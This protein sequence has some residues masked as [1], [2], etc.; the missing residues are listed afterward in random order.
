MNDDV[1]PSHRLAIIDLGTNT[2]HLL[3]VEIKTNGVPWSVL[4]RERE[5]VKLGAGGVKEIS[6]ESYHRAIETMK[7]FHLKCIKF[8]HP[9][10]IAVG[11]ACLRVARNAT[12]LIREVFDQT[13]IQIEVISGEK[14][15]LLISKGIV[16]SLPEIKRPFLIMDIG[17][18]SIEFIVCDVSGQIS[19]SKS[20]QVGVAIL[21]KKFHLNDPIS[22]LELQEIDSFLKNELN[23]LIVHLDQF[24]QLDL[25]GASGTFEVLGDALSSSKLNQYTAHVD[26]KSFYPFYSRVIKTNLKER[27]DMPEIPDSRADL[28]VV[29]LQTIHFILGQY[30][31]QKILVSEFA[32]KEGLIKESIEQTT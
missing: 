28:I 1:S 30:P 31:F 24:P 4:C 17:G 6:D 23:D 8:G 22:T 10:V 7:M 29:A 2:F 32:L 9:K 25:I 18:G 3:I 13:G 15:A 21:F 12:K 11:T 14:E 27:M 5:Y 26:I 16:L 20:Y 19:F